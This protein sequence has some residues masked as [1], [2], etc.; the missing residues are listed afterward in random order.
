MHVRSRTGRI[1]LAI[2]LGALLLG[3]AAGFRGVLGIEASAEGVRD[4]VRAYGVVAPAV[5]VTLVGL[6]IFI[7]IPSQVLLVG[8]GLCFGALGGTVYGA[9][10]LLLSGTL[11]YA[12]TRYA[13]RDA[14]RRRVPEPILRALDRADSRTGGLAIFAGT[15]YPVGP[16][17]A[18]HAAAALTSMALPAFVLSLLAGGA[19]RAAS[20][21]YFGAKI[22]EG[23]PTTLAAAAGLLLALA[24]LPLL[25]PA[26]RAFLLRQRGRGLRPSSGEGSG[27]RPARPRAVGREGAAGASNGTTPQG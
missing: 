5:F 26:G 14:V 21:A 2:G 4:A 22:L 12:V 27:R 15:A 13:V 3:A 8:G 9:L 6:R 17:S 20:Y 24:G 19:V 25:H 23:D 7:A 10:G 18:Y 11:T 1:L 16:L